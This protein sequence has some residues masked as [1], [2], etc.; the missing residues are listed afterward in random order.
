MPDDGILVSDVGIHH[1]WIIQEWQASA[2]RTLLQSWGFASMGFGVAGVLGAKLAAPDRPVVGV[3]GD[4]GFLM[5]PS[6]VATAVETGISP[7]W[8]VWNNGGYV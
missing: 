5:M 7:T 6:V 4:G 2:P 1:N 8:I 3:V